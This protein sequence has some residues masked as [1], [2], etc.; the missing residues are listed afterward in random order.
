MSGMKKT[1]AKVSM[2]AMMSAMMNPDAFREE[3]Y[4]MSPKEVEA[5]KL[6]KEQERI[7][8]LKEKGV[9]EFYYGE[10]VVYAR[11]QKNADRKARNLGYVK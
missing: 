10:N 11:T 7:T 6:A 4:Q 3:S 5:L 9:H 2:I 1:L 8:R